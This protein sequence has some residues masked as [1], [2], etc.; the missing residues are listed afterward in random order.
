MRQYF[1][2][3]LSSRSPECVSQLFSCCYLARDGS[4]SHKKKNKMLISFRSRYVRTGGGGFTLAERSRARFHPTASH[5]TDS[6]ADLLNLSARHLR[7]YLSPHL[8]RSHF[9]LFDGSVSRPIEHLSPDVRLPRN[10][11][12][13]GNRAA[14]RQ[15]SCNFISF[16]LLYCHRKTS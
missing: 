9:S 6:L 8:F 16:T 3:S 7:F 14:R 12:V 2:N 13:R 15:D 10:Y 11:N 5:A 1:C 4:E